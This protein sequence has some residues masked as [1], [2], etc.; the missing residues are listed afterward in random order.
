[1]A[2]Y[3]ILAHS[4]AVQHRVL[5]C[6]RLCSGMALTIKTN[7]G[8]LKVE[9]FCAQ[10]PKTCKNFL[11]L[12]ASGYYDNTNF[13]RN[14]KGFMI[15]GGDPTGTGKGGQ[16]IYGGYFEDEFVSTLKHERRGCLSMVNTGPNTNGSQFFITYSR[17]PHLNGVYTTFGRLIDGLDTLD[18][19]EKDSFRVPTT[20][21]RRAMYRL[22]R[23]SMQASRRAASSLASLVWSQAAQEGSKLAVAAPQQGVSWSFTELEQRAGRI[24]GGLA[25]HGVTRGSTV[26]TDLPNSADN[27]LL[28][29]SCSSGE[30][31]FR[32]D[33]EGQLAELQKVTDLKLAVTHRSGDAVNAALAKYQLPAKPVVVEDGWHS[34]TWSPDFDLDGELA[35]LVQSEVPERVS[36]AG[37]DTLLGYWSSTKALTIREAI[38]EMGAAAKE[39]LAITAADRVLVS[40]TLCHAFGIGSAVTG[41]V[42]PG[43]S[44]IRGCGS[45][46]QRAEA[47]LAAMVSHKCSLLFADI[48]TLKALPTPSGQ[49]QLRGGVCKVGSGA[50]F[51]DLREAKLGPNGEMRP[52]EYAGVPLVAIGKR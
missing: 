39:R 41:L 35:P 34:E 38:E 1:M 49:L 5:R 26:V 52:L 13:H 28:Q 22:Q 51:L 23:S 3:R 9:L 24:A 50:E 47:T 43:A 10:T 4:G 6:A 46:S 45:P 32:A 14:I 2:N 20:L 19:M 15:Q 12:A 16:S 48:H 33:D 29:V 36:V 11:A 25:K 18:K 17:Q 31:S 21:P 30:A 40:I 27:L 8:P 44:G 7:L 37:D 42:L